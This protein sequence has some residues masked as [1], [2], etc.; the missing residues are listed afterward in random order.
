VCEEDVPRAGEL[1]M[2]S[3][4]KPGT[5][6][7]EPGTGIMTLVV[8]AAVVVLFMPQTALAGDPC[9]S[10]YSGPDAT[11]QVGAGALCPP[12]TGISGETLA[13]YLPK[14]AAVVSCKPE[15]AEI[16]CV[17]PGPNDEL[18][19][20]I[21]EAKNS[22]GFCKPSAPGCS[23]TQEA[24]SI[25]G[26][27][28][29]S[30]STCCVDKVGGPA[31]TTCLGKLKGAESECRG[32][33]VSGDEI[34]ATNSE[35]WDDYL[36]PDCAQTCV[37]KKGDALCQALSAAK[38]PK[39]KGKYSCSDANNCEEN[40]VLTQVAGV[41]GET[42]TGGKVCCFSKVAAAKPGV[43]GK[44][45]TL[46]DP[47]SGLNFPR[48]IGNVIRTFSGIAGSLALLMFVYGGIMW[49]LSGGS[50]DKVKKAQKI[51]VNA[52]IGL[53]LI[54]SAYTFVA[55]IVDTILQPPVKT[56]EETQ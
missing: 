2:L 51:L 41:F 28:K 8:V 52:A 11:C 18:C 37:V 31:G 55:S 3:I 44:P 53:V 12:N 40:T 33:G 16:C 42:C 10:G 24:I 32:G 48:L 27:C 23:P 49:I 38:V 35:L 25:D 9:N 4:V 19:K 20:L 36:E 54:F 43:A 50:P 5:G 1:F 26:V 29:D 14:Y 30:G 7:R 39:A 17:L 6:N 47:L 45:V 15:A 13:A 21:G 46:P 22:S 34:D 56:T